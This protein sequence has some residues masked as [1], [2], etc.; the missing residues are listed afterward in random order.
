MLGGN[1][2][3]A[4]NRIPK[5]GSFVANFGQGGVG[6]KTIISKEDEQIARSVSSFLVE[7]GIHFAGLD[8]IDGFLTEINIT[9][10]T[11]VMQINALENLALEKKIVD[12]FEKLARKNG[13]PAGI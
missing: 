2:L 6:K 12:Y 9:C 13:A 7:S 4:V 1:V 3:G 8:V 10:P 5:S 11:G